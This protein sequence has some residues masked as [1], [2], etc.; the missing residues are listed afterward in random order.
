MA[1]REA[2]A[3]LLGAFL[4]AIC[5]GAATVFEAQAARASARAKGVDPRL[6]LRMVQNWRF[7]VGVGLDVLGFL[8]EFAALRLL[9]LFVVQAAVAS[10][11]AVTALLASWMLGERLGGREWVGVAGVCAGLALLSVSAGH[12]GS[13]HPGRG[14][15]AGLAIAVVVLGLAGVGLARIANPWR[16][17]GLG[18]CSGLLFGVVALAARTLPSLDA[19]RL[20]REP[21]VYLLIASG[22][23]GYLLLATALQRG[24]VATATAAMVVGETAGPAGVG[25][26]L[27][28]DSARHGQAPVAA[29][30][31]VLAV[32]GAVSLARFGELPPD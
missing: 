21:A 8:F 2:R 20:M 29:F 5:F 17:I 27:L 30:G 10:S 24:S 22:I 12:E 14:F 15:D 4:A 9:P 7:I 25:L 26:L 13:T 1:V 18:L 31:F 28:G 3:S 16:S 6:L 23:G 32:A 11:L 19:V